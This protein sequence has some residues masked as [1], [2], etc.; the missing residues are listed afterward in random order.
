MDDDS[1]RLNARY[2]GIVLFTR[3]IG[4]KASDTQD[5]RV[6][7]GRGAVAYP[8]HVVLGNNHGVLCYWTNCESCGEE[9]ELTLVGGLNVRLWC[10]TNLVSW[11]SP[12]RG[13]SKAA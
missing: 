7:A 3:L 13:D 5:A 8:R 11:R 1:R 4:R 2:Q 9:A 6:T 12:T 10:L